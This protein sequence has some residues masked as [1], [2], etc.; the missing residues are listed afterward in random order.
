[1][2]I[3]CVQSLAPVEAPDAASPSTPVS[4]ARQPKA[5][6]SVSQPYRK[7]VVTSDVRA[8]LDAATVR[9]AVSSFVRLKVRYLLRTNFIMA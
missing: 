2:K 8:T 3:E 4:G 7:I 1:M 6:R 5:D 9:H